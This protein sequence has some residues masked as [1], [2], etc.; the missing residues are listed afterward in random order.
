MKS[1]LSQT[2]DF[3]TKADSFQCPQRGQHFRMW[4]NLKDPVLLFC[5]LPS[6]HC[7]PQVKRPPIPS[8]CLEVSFL[9]QSSTI[10][11]NL[12]SNS[13]KE[14][15]RSKMGLVLINED[16]LSLKESIKMNLKII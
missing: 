3:T 10:L 12:A 4:V 7:L 11:M 16:I 5:S 6:L 13:Y 8:L 1:K 2:E 9:T 15:E 14:Q